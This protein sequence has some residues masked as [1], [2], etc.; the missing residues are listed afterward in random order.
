M[1]KYIL[2]LFALGIF[3]ISPSLVGAQSAT[4]DIKANGSD[5]PVT[6]SPGEALTL[7]WTS[8]N[9]SGCYIYAPVFAGGSSGVT[10][11][12]SYTTPLLSSQN[13][14]TS[15]PDYPTSTT[16]YELK[17]YP[18][19]SNGSIDLNGPTVNNSVTVNP[20]PPPVI[21]SFSVSPTS[22]DLG[23][24]PDLVFSWSASNAEVTSFP[25]AGGGTTSLSACVLFKGSYVVAVGLNAS[26]SHTLS[27]SFDPL[28]YP[29][30][31]GTVTYTL[32]C[33]N[34]AKTAAVAT[35]NASVSVS[36]A[37]PTMPPSTKFK[38]GDRVQVTTP[39]LYVRSIGDI[40]GTQLGTQS[41]SALGTISSGG[42]YSG[43]YYW[44]SVDYDSGADGW[45]A[46][47][48]LALVS[49]STTPPPTT[50]QPI[51]APGD[52]YNWQT[53]APCP[54]TTTTTGTPINIKANGSDGPIT[55]TPGQAVNLSWVSQNVASCYASGGW[56]GTKATSGSQSVSPT[57]TTTYSITCTPTTTTTT[58]TSSTTSFQVG[59]FIKIAGC[60]GC[61]GS[62]NLAV[63]LRTD[64]STPSTTSLSSGVIGEI[65]GGPQ[66]VNGVT[67]WKIY[68]ST[69]KVF[70]GLATEGWV[71]QYNMTLIP[72]P[73]PI[74][75]LSPGIFSGS[76][77]LTWTSHYAT[78]CTAS[79]GWSGTKA[80]NG[81]E[82]MTLTPSA[83]YTLS[84]TGKG[85]TGTASYTAPN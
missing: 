10:T 26:G 85:G 62:T 35:S 27:A 78:S 20:P 51:C 59:D 54:T 61:T 41:M 13:P 18:L 23:V 65:T 47:P 12:G 29:T 32:N 73:Q 2:A 31:T 45:S 46:E 39:T 25:T 4:V 19:Q 14:V 75:Y 77:N 70:S 8:T 38:P 72:A 9:V 37:A 44:W 67:W 50:T 66:V 3:I 33:Y 42:T 68:V 57:Q 82:T 52:L 58:P 53:G 55:I 49:S 28:G 36:G 71:E 15:H 64:P 30:V 7:S 84:C 79:G 80:L 24:R 40:S 83:T 6:L 48:F 76:G 11:S 63:N 69:N 43:G 34:A 22:I 17:C 21:N 74:V 16:T 56:S 60:A 5:G 81:S 1:K